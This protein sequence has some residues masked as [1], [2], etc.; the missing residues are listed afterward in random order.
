[1]TQREF[2][3]STFS[4]SN[5]FYV[6]NTFDLGLP[7]T[8]LAFAC[9]SLLLN[10][11]PQTAQNSVLSAQELVKICSYTTT[12]DTIMVK[13]IFW[14]MKQQKWLIHLTLRDSFVIFPFLFWIYA[15]KWL[16]ILE[17]TNWYFSNS[18]YHCWKSILAIFSSHIA[19]VR[20]NTMIL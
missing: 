9:S 13:S 4:P 5:S 15:K 19:P 6:H 7:N 20:F 10:R 14:N 2:R 16:R 17:I 3:E 11:P 12:S 18:S 1:M 8:Y